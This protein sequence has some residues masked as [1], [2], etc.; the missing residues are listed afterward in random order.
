MSEKIVRG[1]KFF[2]LP[3]RAGEEIERGQ[4]VLVPADHGP[5]GL[6]HQRY[7]TDG[8]SPAPGVRRTDRM[9]RVPCAP[10]GLPNSLVAGLIRR[11]GEKC[12]SW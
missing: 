11:F 10:V 2:R 5:Q 1:L 3:T 6:P 12:L 8:G 7:P 4:V 9:F